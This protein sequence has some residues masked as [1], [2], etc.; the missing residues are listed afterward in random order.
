MITAYVPANTLKDDLNRTAEAQSFIGRHILEGANAK[1][2]HR[3]SG[4][5]GLV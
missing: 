2:S 1:H 4:Q 5:I 3:L